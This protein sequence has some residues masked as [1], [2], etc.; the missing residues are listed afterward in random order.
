MSPRTVR[1]T[2]GLVN[3]VNIHQAVRTPYSEDCTAYAQLG[4]WC[5]HSPSRAYAVQSSDSFD[6]LYIVC[7]QSFSKFP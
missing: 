5:K 2:H 7:F 3:G 1:R 4:E 6:L